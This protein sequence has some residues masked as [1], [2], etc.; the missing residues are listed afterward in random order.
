MSNAA[1]KS[2]IERMKFGKWE[3]IVQHIIALDSNNTKNNFF[4]KMLYLENRVLNTM[5]KK[6]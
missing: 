3:V 1:S 5:S 4:N 2:R 6:K